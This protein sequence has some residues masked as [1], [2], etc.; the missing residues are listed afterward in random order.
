MAA[1]IL[2][3]IRQLG[4]TLGVA[5][6]GIAYQAGGLTPVYVVAAACGGVTGLLALV[7]RK[8]VRVPA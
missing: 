4:Q 2:T 7:P 1:G 5:V 6:L 8:R 3:T